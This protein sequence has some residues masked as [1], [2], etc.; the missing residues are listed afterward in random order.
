MA[1]QS[2]GKTK[3]CGYGNKGKGR[4]M[5]PQGRGPKSL[6]KES[7]K[8][9]GGKDKEEEKAWKQNVSK[10]L[11]TGVDSGITLST[12]VRKKN[13]YMDW[14]RNRYDKKKNNQNVA[15]QLETTTGQDDGWKIVRGHIETLARFVDVCSCNRVWIDLQKMFHV[16]T[17]TEADEHG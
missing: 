11:A 6:A 10:T 5:T 15:F 3:I 4:A 14:T 9:C 7:G 2:K 13:A 12:T 17:N 8:I 16:V 1:T